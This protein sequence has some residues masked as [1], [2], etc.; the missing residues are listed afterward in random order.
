ML[1][2]PFFGKKK[3]LL[4]FEYGMIFASSAKDL[5]VELT[6]ELSKRFEVMLLNEFKSKSATQLAVDMFPN[7]LSVFE[8]TLD[9]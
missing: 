7:I 5:K 3:L 6:P 1:D 9:K 2:F 8:T 4:A